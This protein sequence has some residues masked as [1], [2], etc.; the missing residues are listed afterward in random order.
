MEPFNTLTIDQ[1][2]GLIDWFQQQ[3]KTGK[4]VSK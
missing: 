3:K 1:C 4:S 2:D